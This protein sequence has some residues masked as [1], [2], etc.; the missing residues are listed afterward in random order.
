MSDLK[1]RIQQIFDSKKEKITEIRRHIHQYPEL[2]F[3]EFE[4]QKFISKNLDDLGIE[5]YSVADTGV[6]GMIRGQNP[7]KKLVVL[8]GDIDALPIF[9]NT[10]L[11]FASRNEG[12]MHACGHDVHT[13]CVLG[14]G[15]I[16]NE[17]KDEF[18]GSVKLLFQPGEEKLPGGATKV[19]ASGEL[20]K[21]VPDV[22]I[23]QH[24]FA[25][26]EV[27]KVGFRPGLY[28][29][30][31]DEIYIDVKGPGGHAAMPEKTVDVLKASSQLI[32]ALKDFVDEN[33]PDTIPTVLTFGK[34][35]G[36]GATNVIPKLV[37]IEGTFRT[38]DES[39]R[40]G[41]HQNLERITKSIAE[42][43]G[44]EIEIEI[45]KGYPCLINDEEATKNSKTA[46]QLFLGEDNVIDLD[47]RMTSED[48]AFYTQQYKSCFYRL[49]I[50]TPGNIIT[51]LHSPEFVVDER[52]LETG[53]KLMAYLAIKNS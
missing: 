35:E 37:H 4:T 21:P 31:A 45:R 43:S 10:G 36:K 15:M 7:E 18:E 30:S 52:A 38:M 44:A 27:G 25:E 53:S 16:L 42:E 51:G 49:G 20:N 32:L 19:I 13:S 29:A 3:Q 11:E 9:E 39:W 47:L 33:T 24:V 41:V 48:F 50:R 1:E 2:S 6:I 5:N 12:V 14:A 46:A 26:L 34:I 22:I 28:M 23:G 8:R 40:A 17:L